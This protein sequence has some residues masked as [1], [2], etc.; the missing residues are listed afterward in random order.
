MSRIQQILSKADRDGTTAGLTS[1]GA[2]DR[3]RPRPVSPIRAEDVPA[4]AAAL[5]DGVPIT[6][7]VPEGGTLPGR[8]VFTATL[9]KQLVAALAPL[10]PAAEQYRALRMRVA[11]LEAGSARHILAVTSPGRGD[12]KTLTVLNLALSMAQEFDRR[13]L[14]IDADLRHAR[15][16]A[17]L[18]IPREP[19]L[20]DVLSGT[21]P[22]EQALVTLAGHRL[23]V[24]PA[25][26]A[27]QQP[28]ELLGAAAMRRLMEGLRRHF[29][30]IVLDTAAAQTAEAGAV[31]P[32]VD[33]VLIVVRAGH[34]GRPG[35]E[36]ALNAVPAAKL[37]GM[38][39]NDSRTMDGLASA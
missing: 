38:V 27:H 21:T 7:P 24:L 39:L 16:H 23:Q 22:I 28:S 5:V 37:M 15:I 6:S 35:I 14:I 4:P 19:G 29:D 32:C 31:E 10:S 30:R 11:Q 36:R 17:L 1:P 9:H 18:G 26:A 34:T 25:G 3:A 13:T 12:G 8:P 33:G 20:T 2:H